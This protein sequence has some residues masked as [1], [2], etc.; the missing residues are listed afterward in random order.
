[1]ARPYSFFHD[2]LQDVATQREIGHQPL[3]LPFLVA[4]SGLAMF[5]CAFVAGAS[6]NYRLM[7][8]LGVLA[9]L[10]EDMNSRISRQS[11][12]TAVLFLVLMEKRFSLH[13]PQQMKTPRD[14]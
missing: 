3:E 2:L 7:F 6:Y 9:Y 11:L 10:V 8:L 4:I 1:L 12:W 5:C 13:C 14:G